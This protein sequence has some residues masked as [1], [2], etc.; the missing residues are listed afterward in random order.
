[1]NRECVIYEKNREYGSRLMTA[2]AQ[3]AAMRFRVQLFT[4]RE[5]LE[6][7]IKSNEPD[8]LL[9]GEECYYEGIRKMYQGRIIM[10]LDEPEDSDSVEKLYGQNV[11]GVYRY[12]S[13]EI[14]YKEVAKGGGLVRKKGSDSVNTITVYS[15]VYAEPKVTFVLTLAK[16]LG[17]KYKVLYL[18]LEEFS[19][20]DELLPDVERGTLSDAIYYYRQGKAAAL[21]KIKQII[22]TVSGF[23]YITPVKCAEDI[24]SIEP[25]EMLDFIDC[26]GKEMAYDVVILDVS[27]SVREKWKI[28]ES[29]TRLYM[30]VKDDY[31]S[32]RKIACFETYYGG[33]GKEG[34]LD[35]TVKV[36]LP[37]GEG[38]VSTE[39]WSKIHM[40]G[41]Y[42]YV[43]KL[44]EQWEV[45]VERNR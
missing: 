34:I 31:I 41:M 28:L 8:V 2:V 37:E 25:E 5:H 36:R 3:R 14:L 23:D 22:N 21:D 17:E 9:T 24:S 7:Y 16:V 11:V 19:G 13:S 4:D 12:Q 43:K 6:S 20:L 27:E 40:G 38:G 29:S 15:P 33:T 32:A 10:L 26:I 35:N 1:M 42:R 45:S 44:T 30:P 18:N 39:F